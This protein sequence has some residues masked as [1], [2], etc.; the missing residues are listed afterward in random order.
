[1]ILQEL[2]DYY[3][4][5]AS[6]ANAKISPSGF[7]E[8]SA[9][10]EAV[11]SE[12]GDLLSIRSLV[13][14]KKRKTLVMPQNMKGPSISASPV[15]DNF[16][17]IFGVSGSKGE[18][19]LE[20]KKWQTAKDLHEELF[21]QAQSK[22]AQA[23]VKFF[24][25]WDI[26]EAWD[27]EQILDN[28]SETG[29]AF[30]GNVIFRL[31]GTEHYF[32]ECKEIEDIWL[33]ENQRKDID[34]GQEIRQCSITGEFAPIARLHEKFSGVKGAMS[35]GA[36]LVC[37]KKDSDHSYN[38]TQLYNAPVSQEAM[39]KYST[40]LKHL[41]SS[42]EQKMYIGEDTV[43]FWASSNDKRYT[44]IFSN[45]FEG[46]S[47]A[48]ALSKETKADSKTEEII[49]SVLQSGQDGLF[50][51]KLNLEGDLDPNTRFCILGL[52]PNAGRISVR[53]FYKDTFGAFCERIKAHYDDIKIVGNKPHIKIRSLLYATV[54]SKSRDK[55]VNPLLG[56]AVMRSILTGA[57]YPQ[58]LLNQTIIRTKTETMITHARAAIIKGFL[59]RKN[60]I[61]KKEEQLTMYLNQESKNVAYVLGRTFAILEMIQKKALDQNINTT[62][63]DKY[64]STACSNPALVFP[65]L[66]KLS[67]HH[68][69][70]IE[71]I[72][73]DKLLGQ[74]I[75]LI[76]GESFPKTMNMEDQ[77]RFILGYYQQNQKLYE[78][79]DTAAAQ[80]SEE[81]DE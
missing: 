56:G 7:E 34:A 44:G 63:R 37:F 41:L 76:E 51:E 32:H 64:F 18:K 52:A 6:D 72:Y 4:V 66:I 73:F 78:K 49:K 54:S 39:F 2:F 11:L 31:R 48:N 22:E 23:I 12:E 71:G 9:A 81:V 80:I 1:M 36:S 14:D 74:C 70:K 61:L 35:T 19:Q 17:Y 55:K 27:N 77:G 67:Q 57:A 28:Y 79:K 21:G 53:Y 69:A 42:T 68:L 33:A 13:K 38:L 40:A 59:M 15:C 25:K 16:A 75:S 46:E 24:D 10:Y 45:L 47:T 65:N 20:E 30:A 8:N 62:I 29:N 60:R 26:N 58:L 50:N 43:V 3:D 5:L